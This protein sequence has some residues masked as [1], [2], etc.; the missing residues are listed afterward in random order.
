MQELT[1]RHQ[2]VGKILNNHFN[3]YKTYIDIQQLKHIK[4]NVQIFCILVFT[5]LT[6][7]C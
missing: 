3:K 6:T 7:Y 2:I 1:S 4:Y 5:R